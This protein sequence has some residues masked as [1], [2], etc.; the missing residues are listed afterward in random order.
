MGYGDYI[1]WTAIIRDINKKLFNFENIWEK[2]KYLESIKCKDDEDIGV[3]D[4]KFTCSNTPFK[5]FLYC[6]NLKNST[7]TMKFTKHLDCNHIFYNNP[8]VTSDMNYKNIV[9][10]KIMSNYYWKKD[11]LE[12]NAKGTHH[13]V[14][15]DQHWVKILADKFK[16]DEYQL[17]GD[18]HFS[19]NE[20][21][22]V[23]EYLPSRDFIII[24]Y[25]CK[26]ASRSYPKEKMQQVVNFLKDRILCV[27]I[28]PDSFKGTNFETLENIETIKGIFSFRETI[29]FSSYAKFAILNHGG[30]SNG[31]ACFGI[32][33]VCL[34][35]NLFNPIS[36]VT[37][38][39]IPYLYCDHGN[40]CYDYNCEKCLE[41]KKETKS[42]DLLKVIKKEFKIS[43]KI[44][45]AFNIIEIF[46]EKEDLTKEIFDESLIW[47]LELINFL[48][49]NKRLNTKT[50]FIF[51]IDT[52]NNDNLIPRFISPIKLHKLSETDKKKINKISLSKFK[53]TYN[54]NFDFSENSYNIASKIFHKYFKFDKIILDEVNKLNISE[55]T[56]GIHYKSSELFNPIKRYE[57]I[58]IIKDF[59]K[60]NCVENI[61]CVTDKQ[62]FIDEIKSLYPNYI[63]DYIN[64]EEYN[65]EMKQQLTIASI[66]GMLVL[67]KCKTVIKTSSSLGCFSKII[68]PS[69]DLYT[70][71]SLKKRS[72]PT[73]I[74]KPYKSESN[75]INLILDRTID[76]NVLL[77][78]RTRFSFHKNI[79]IYYFY[80][81]KYNYFDNLIEFLNFKTLM[82]FLLVLAPFMIIP[83]LTILPF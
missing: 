67:S 74:V 77:Y 15:D 11:F 75:L 6:S 21:E 52:L 9:Y 73:G 41:M 14:W 30:L 37:N 28:I 48:D 76:D 58:L 29:C 59:I 79:F 31:V 12:M 69:L 60:N 40:F 62:S 57:M 26:I 27:Q 22:K 25:Q 53:K 80:Y 55:N 70:V 19:K 36:T 24:N 65:Y 54:T 16:L 49:V 10:F 68:N 72:F 4:I 13:Y 56:L 34:Y 33:T 35:S 17:H 66:V 51:N 7:K 20:I 8:N 63:I 45:K 39:E 3:L 50:K 61:F 18:F 46:S 47:L 81:L 82:F 38:S 5:F 78:E 43:K 23:K 32:K 2:I 64:V 83:F 1:F 71:S 44:N 42:K